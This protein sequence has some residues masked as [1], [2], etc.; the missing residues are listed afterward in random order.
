MTLV[1]LV[2]LVAASSPSSYL[3]PAVWKVA[4]GISVIVFFFALNE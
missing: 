1:Y 3:V 4:W 2:V